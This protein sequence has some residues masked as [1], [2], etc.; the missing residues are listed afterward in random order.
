MTKF[1]EK[2]QNLKI[3]WVFLGKTRYLNCK[4]QSRL[5]NLLKNAWNEDDL[6]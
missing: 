4:T 6:R 5:E 1:T 3:K 2:L